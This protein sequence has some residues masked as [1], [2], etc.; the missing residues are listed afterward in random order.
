MGLSPKLV[1]ISILRSSL[2]ALIVVLFVSKAPVED[3]L[4]GNFK[5]IDLIIAILL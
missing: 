3:F 5:L 4:K 2:T 1:K